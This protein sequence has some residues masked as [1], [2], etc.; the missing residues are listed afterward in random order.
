MKKVCKLIL[1]EKFILLGKYF[2]SV[3]AFSLVA[4]SCAEEEF[5]KDPDNFIGEEVEV[6]FS[7]DV[8]SVSDATPKLRSIGLAEENTI[9]TINLLAF[10]KDNTGSYFNYQ[11]EGALAADNTPGTS[12]QKCR[13][14]VR[15]ANY[16]Q[17]LVMI[18]NAGTLIGNI[19]NSKDWADTP[20]ETFLA[21]L[22]YS[23]SENEIKWNVISASNYDALPMWGETSATITQNT[24]QLSISLLRMLAKIDIQLDEAKLNELKSV[25]KLK[26]VRL[27]NTNTKGRIVPNSANVQQSGNNV[28][29]TAPS[30]PS[31][32]GKYLGPL[33]YQETSDFATGK[34]DEAMKG[35]IYTFETKAPDSTDP[36]GALDATSVVI[37]GIYGNDA[38]ETFYRVDFQKDEK[39]QDILR[40]HCYLV[41]I[42]SVTGS[43][44]ETEDEAFHN[45]A[46]NMSTNILVWDENNM[47]D[48]IFDG[49]WY[50][51]VSNHS[52]FVPRTKEINET[53]LFVKTDYNP[54]G[55]L[56]TGWYVESVIDS[57]TKATATWL[58]VYPMS[59]PPN[60]LENVKIETLSDNN[61]SE[62]RTATIVFAAGRLRYPVTVSQTLIDRPT[63]AVNFWYSVGGDPIIGAL[64]PDTLTF[65]FSDPTGSSTPPLHTIQI[66]VLPATIYLYLYRTDVPNIAYGRFGFNPDLTGVITTRADGTHVL[67]IMPPLVTP[68][69]FVNGAYLKEEELTLQAA[70]GPY[71]VKQS[72]ILKHVYTP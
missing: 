25:F 47:S 11:Y 62:I 9:K 30:L 51:S 21:N 7:I 32:P 63:I 6:V 69:D 67:S 50:L 54:I 66:T 3:I 37:G 31:T 18:T 26:S 52:I 56:S 16:E 38:A 53:D 40:N 57:A 44:Y 1:P 48:V 39:F 20:K 46:V 8:P 27:Y 22:E 71:T 35:A 13:V 49:Q 36:L 14:K 70:N 12:S 33:I 42:V 10:R 55:P 4:F 58:S 19:I 59:G 64:V 15:M 60:E 34:I 17:E 5:G 41:N 72:I 24:N 2:L 61:T 23:L 29:V 45:R 65:T 28:S 68:A 43:G